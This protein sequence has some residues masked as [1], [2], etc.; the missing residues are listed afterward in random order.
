[1]DVA[2]IT[3]RVKT[4]SP[5][6]I[7]EYTENDQAFPAGM[8][9]TRV[10]ADAWL[11][12]RATAVDWTAVTTALSVANNG[13]LTLVSGVSLISAGAINLKV[14]GDTD[15]YLSITTVADIPTLTATGAAAL[16]LASNLLR[17]S[18][19]EQGTDPDTF[20][21]MA[22]LQTVYTNPS[23]WE[24]VGLRVHPRIK[25]TDSAF[26]QQL[27]GISGEAGVDD[28][29]TQ[30]WTHARSLVGLD[31]FVAMWNGA[32]GTITG[33]IGV[34]GSGL[35]ESGT[36]TNYYALYASHPTGAGTVT[37][38]YGLYIEAIGEGAS[39]NYGLY[40]AGGKSYLGDTLSM[41]EGKFV[42]ISSLVANSGI[43]WGG[44]AP[45]SQNGMVL[46][47]HS[48]WSYGWQFWTVDGTPAMKLQIDATG[49]ILSPNSILIKPSGDTDDYFTLATVAGIPTIYGTG[50]YLRI[51][52]A[53]ATSHSLASED[54]LMVSGK[55]EVDGAIFPDGSVF[56]ADLGGVKFGTGS[57]MNFLWDT[58]DADA[59]ILDVYL[60]T[61]ASSNIPGM[62]LQYTQIGDIGLF[63]GVTQP[64]YASLNRSGKYTSSSS[65][66]S[67]AGA[68]TPIMKLV[69]GFTNSVIGDIVRVTAGTA[70][71]PGWYW[72]TTVTSADE[73]V[74]DRNWTTGDCTGGTFV[75]YHSFTLLSAEGICTRITDGAP[76]D[77]SVEIDRD[78]WL[79]LDVGQANG[80]LYWRANNAW[81]Y[82]DA[83]AGLS[84]TAEERV[85]NGHSWEV[86]DFGIVQIDK[87]HTDG[88][89][90]GLLY[91]ADR[92]L[93][94]MLAK[95]VAF[96]AFEESI[97]GKISRMEQELAELRASRSS[98]PSPLAGEG[99]GE[100]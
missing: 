58:F 9:R 75:A 98:A 64:F 37:N 87:H 2:Q 100:A 91:P 80:R 26:T 8:W 22:Y 23:S 71:V 51:G 10:N 34:Q 49:T 88:A 53:A 38:A 36:L 72:I 70:D 81:H 35:I 44:N 11:L 76:T 89:P 95:S 83:T 59:N 31:G 12:E 90:H 74:L 30:N 32:A 19:S 7:F 45:F 5:A 52:D 16:G 33:A 29:N 4:A 73:V 41:A 96:K 94:E 18:I 78:G 63:D 27:I 54:D 92:W 93:E 84:F 14:S 43:G 68:A 6:P 24:N 66:F 21:Y 67:D 77:S 55:L 86:G 46:G 69:G 62:V 97:E 79:I 48:T 99:R 20:Y 60:N 42:E 82:V 17:G 50:A 57:D 65:A 28:E 15:D 13:D 25:K 56:F 47:I 61:S 85:M 3:P 39:L 1:M 40:V